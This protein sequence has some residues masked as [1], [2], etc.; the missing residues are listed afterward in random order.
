MKRLLLM[1]VVSM[2]AT[3]SMNA[4]NAHDLIVRS[5]VGVNLCTLT[6][7]DDFKQKLGWTVGAG[8]DFCI[9]D[10]WAVSLDISRDYIGAKSKLLDKKLNLEY[11]SFG[12]IA[13]FYATPWLALQAGPEIGFLLK[14]KMD[15]TSYK[16]AYKKTEFSLPLGVSFEPKIG[17]NDGSLIID[18]RYRLGLSNVNK[19]DVID[20]NIH[21]SAFIFTVGYKFNLL[22]E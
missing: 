1:A 4:Q 19:K 6:G 3:M 11:L 22:G 5:R 15:D 21:N 8:F 20:A 18:L 16:D 7:N 13:K 9:T 12:P 14:A 10:Q 17:S 2:M